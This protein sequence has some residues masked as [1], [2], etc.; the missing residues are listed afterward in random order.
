[1]YHLKL[2][3]RGIST[4]CYFIRITTNLLRKQWRIVWLT[5]FAFE[6]DTWKLLR[7]TWKKGYMEITEGKYTVESAVMIHE[8][9]MKIT[10]SF[11]WCQKKLT[12]GFQCWSTMVTQHWF[13]VEMLAGIG[14]LRFLK[15]AMRILRWNNVL[16]FNFNFPCNL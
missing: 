7:D 2:N 8:N 10:V 5:T 13:N 15:D 1:M 14:H 4:P 11:C 3:S 9:N 16:S 12:Y 6:C